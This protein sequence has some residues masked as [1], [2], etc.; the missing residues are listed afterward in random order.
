LLA[1]LNRL[2]FRQNPRRRQIV[3]RPANPPTADPSVH[4]PKAALAPPSW[5]DVSDAKATVCF[6][7][8]LVLL[9]IPLCHSMSLSCQLRTMYAKP[10]NMSTKWQHKNENIK[11]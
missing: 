9:F 4:L 11:K 7:S 3:A 6:G 2:L 8:V 10:E 1:N 5:P